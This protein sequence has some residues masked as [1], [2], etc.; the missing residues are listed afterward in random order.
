MTDICQFCM[1]GSNFGAEKAQLILWN[2]R[3]QPWPLVSSKPDA[4]MLLADVCP[5]CDTQRFN[6]EEVPRLNE[7]IAEFQNTRRV[8]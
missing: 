7:K 2:G 4:P 1:S 5:V 3:W 8:L 6:A